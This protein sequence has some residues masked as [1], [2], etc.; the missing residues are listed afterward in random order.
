MT[1]NPTATPTPR[2]IASLVGF[3]SLLEHNGTV[4]IEVGEDMRKIIAT[5]ETE[6]QAATEEQQA[7]L[8]TLR[9]RDKICPT[10]LE[11]EA[12]ALVRALQEI[13]AVLGIDKDSSPRQIV[14]ATT[15]MKKNAERLSEAAMA[16][17]MFDLA[18]HRLKNQA[19][20]LLLTRRKLSSDYQDAVLASYL[21]DLARIVA[22][23]D[24]QWPRPMNAARA[25]EE[26][27]T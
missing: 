13:V 18:Y 14:A 23:P 21:D 4:A 10:M 19:T 25:Q 9:K 1:T 16:L 20:R 7:K 12:R 5:L 26:K 8:E 17:G 11:A 3:V 22:E 24:P 27:K 2:T 6:L 15:D